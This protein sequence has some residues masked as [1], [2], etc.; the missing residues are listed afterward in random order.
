MR[1]AIWGLCYAL[2]VATL[3][4][5]FSACDDEPN[6][7]PGPPTEPVQYTCTYVLY[8]N[9]PYVNDDATATYN[10]CIAAFAR[11]CEDEW[12]DSIPFGLTV[13]G[14]R[15]VSPGVDEN[16]SVS[17]QDHLRM[18]FIGASR[19][20]ADPLI[21]VFK[22]LPPKAV[23][24]NEFFNHCFHLRRAD[25]SLVRENAYWTDLRNSTDSNIREGLE[26][27]VPWTDLAVYTYCR[28]VRAILR[29]GPVAGMPTF[30]SSG[31]VEEQPGSLAKK[32]VIPVYVC[33][34][35]A[36]QTITELDVIDDY[37][38]AAILGVSLDAPDPIGPGAV[39]WPDRSHH[40]A[41]FVHFQHQFGLSNLDLDTQCGNNDAMHENLYATIMHEFGHNL[42]ERDVEPE[43]GYHAAGEH[44]GAAT[45]GYDPARCTMAADRYATCN[46]LYCTNTWWDFAS[47]YRWVRK[48]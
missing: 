32:M 7:V 28:T 8:P 15:S 25:G 24:A 45:S 17:L 42:V 12:V 3:Y 33:A 23:E 38:L 34:P 47:S 9:L 13:S 41:I 43:P 22:W 46:G 2:L 5:A 19:G 44:C 16:V 48:N 14:P 21:Y 35:P 11:S 29:Q 6:Y 27:N 36:V 30:L 31:K 37:P 39:G 1:A 4:L 40:M 18:E 10:G 20:A 26:Q